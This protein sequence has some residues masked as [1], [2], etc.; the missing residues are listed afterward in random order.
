[1]ALQSE[2]VLD[3]NRTV[4][5]VFELVD[6][7]PLDLSFRLLPAV[8]QV[9]PHQL[10]Q[11]S[12][13]QNAVTIHIICIRHHVALERSDCVLRKNHGQHRRP[14][15][16]WPT[17]LPISCRS[18]VECGGHVEPATWVRPPVLA[19]RRQY[20]TDRSQITDHSDNAESLQR[21]FAAVPFGSPHDQVSSI[22]AHLQHGALPQLAIAGSLDLL[23]LVTTVQ[24]HSPPSGY[25]HSPY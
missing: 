25:M 3:S 16:I 24:L 14:S 13:R 23:A 12:V 20:C 7:Q 10:L 15:Y 1:M 21:Q 5:H 4:Q 22:V 8:L 17:L 6:E 19:D 11:L 9:L 18:T 2:R